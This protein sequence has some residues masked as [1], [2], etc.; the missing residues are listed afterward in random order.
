MRLLTICAFLLAASTAVGAEPSAA[1]FRDLFDGKSLDGWVVEGVEKDKAGV[2]VWSVKDG[3][4][5]C[6]GSGGGFLRFDGQEFADFTLRVEYRFAE[7]D[8][9]V[10]KPKVGNSGIGIRTRKYDPM[11]AAS[12]RPSFYSFEVQLMDDAGKTPD[13]HSTASLYR[14]KAASANPV[15]PAP[16][17]NT[18]EIT[19]KG[20]KY[21]ISV[22][23]QQVLEADQTELA[24]LEKGKPK[25]V[26]APKD[27]P[28]KGYVSLQNHGSKI[29]FR[30]VQV[31]ELAK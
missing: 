29:E 21:Y 12:T 17:W 11:K 4:I 20:P 6:Q 1:S 10:A 23:G 18:I 22:N 27:K 5:A 7:P 28:L 24:D 9:T 14:Y 2:P 13:V 8:K 30:K 3:H 16:E 31:K 19:C 25:D 15:K 26:A